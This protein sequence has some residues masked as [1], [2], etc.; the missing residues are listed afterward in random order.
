MKALITGT[1]QAA[2]MAGAILCA[3]LLG[4]WLAV[5]TV[6]GLGLLS[7]VARFVHVTAAI[8]WVG[9]IWF[10]NFVQLT[11][12]E[13]GDDAERAVVLRL[14]APRVAWIFRHASHLALASGVVLLLSTG[15]MLDRWV[16]VSAVYVPPVKAILLWLGTI[17]AIAMW[18]IVH[19]VLWPSLRIVT[20]EVTSDVEGKIQARARIRT[21]ARINL[22][23]ALPVTFAMVAA[24]H[25]Y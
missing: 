10:V 17:G 19:L 5:S 9:M 24:A 18:G 12:M 8:V 11:A 6:D 2:A 4:G 21:F 7:F 22:V 14:I 3:V 16:F 13:A 1:A 20:G 15:Y 25:L 23:L